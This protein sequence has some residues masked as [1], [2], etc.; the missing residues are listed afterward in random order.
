LA[1][2]VGCVAAWLEAEAGRVRLEHCDEG[3]TSSVDVLPAF[4]PAAGVTPP[5]HR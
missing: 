4:R 2:E 3:L 1:D 5:A